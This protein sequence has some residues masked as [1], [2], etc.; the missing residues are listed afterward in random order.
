MI[1]KGYQPKPE[2]SK[3]E[4]RIHYPRVFGSVYAPQEKVYVATARNLSIGNFMTD[5]IMYNLR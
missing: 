5:S 3:Q 1:S 4:T 2:K